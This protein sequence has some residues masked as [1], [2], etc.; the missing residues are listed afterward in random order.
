MLSGR[1][2]QGQKQQGMIRQPWWLHGTVLRLGIH[3]VRDEE[4]RETYARLGDLRAAALLFRL[5]NA[6]A[7]DPSDHIRNELR[8]NDVFL[9]RL[10]EL[11][12][13]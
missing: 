11:D 7:E 3:T 1:W 4:K 2:A 13:Q 5:S 9:A 8:E 6:E 10:D 12:A